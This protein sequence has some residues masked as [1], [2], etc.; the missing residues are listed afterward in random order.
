M[1]CLGDFGH[2]EEEAVT[3]GLCRKCYS[4]ARPRVKS[5]LTSW[6][7]LEALGYA[8]PKTRDTR[9]EFETKLAA[10]RVK[11]AP[12]QMQRSDSNPLV[13]DPVT[14]E[15]KL[16]AQIPVEYR[17]YALRLAASDN[18]I[19]KLKEMDM[20]TQE[21]DLVV[22]PPKPSLRERTLAALA[23]EKEVAEAVAPSVAET[24]PDPM[25]GSPITVDDIQDL[26]DTTMENVA[27]VTPNGLLP[28]PPVPP[29]AGDD[30]SE[31]ELAALEASLPPDA[32]H[33]SE[34]PM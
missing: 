6:E 4:I 5:G 3:R 8:A 10:A 9:T 21:V 20:V 24:K 14:G 7:E 27:P 32:P 22:E 1:K 17:E 12:A 11:Q 16:L 25:T 34:V 19:A 18:W 31:A 2:C 33:A 29:G 15:P 23:A 30:V 28:T 13:P 26:T